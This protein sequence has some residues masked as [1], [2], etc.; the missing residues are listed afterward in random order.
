M[1]NYRPF[2]TEKSAR[3]YAM[4]QR[5]SILLFHKVNV[6]TFILSEDF[7]LGFFARALINDGDASR[8]C[9]APAFLWSFP[10]LLVATILSGATRAFEIVFIE[11]WSIAISSIIFVRHASDGFFI[12]IACKML[13]QA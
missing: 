2:S 4:R 1:S 6:L 5:P 8:C 13:T 11:L 7:T 12:I 3:G 9:S 10:A